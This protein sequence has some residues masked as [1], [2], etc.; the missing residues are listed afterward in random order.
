MPRPNTI[1][2]HPELEAIKTMLETDSIANTAKHFGVSEDALSRFRFKLLGQTQTDDLPDELPSLEQ[3]RQISF[4]YTHPRDPESLEPLIKAARAE[5]RRTRDALED[6]QSEPEKAQE[7]ARQAARSTPSDLDELERLESRLRAAHRAV[8]AAEHNH[9][10]AKLALS[11]LEN[12]VQAWHRDQGAWKNAKEFMACIEAYDHERDTLLNIVATARS[13]L[14]DLREAAIKKHY[15]AVGMGLP[16][17]DPVVL[18]SL[19]L[20][21]GVSGRALDLLMIEGAAFGQYEN[22]HPILKVREDL[23]K[24]FFEGKF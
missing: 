7:A 16:S 12:E 22:K 17:S 23:N 4:G 13:T 6:I 1:T 11:D 14:M 20:E 2:T 18:R 9:A 10:D 5:E 24:V 21:H 15:K 8:E 19:L 3:P